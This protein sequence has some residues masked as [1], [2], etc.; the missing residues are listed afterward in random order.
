MSIEFPNGSVILFF[1]LD[2]KNRMDRIL[3]QEFLTIYCNEVSEISDFNAVTQLMTRLSQTCTSTS[4]KRARPKMLFDCNPPSKK[5]WTYQVF[6]EGIQPISKQP[7][8]N[9]TEWAW[10]RMNPV[11]NSENL[12]E[13]YFDTLENLSARQQKRFLQG[14][15]Q[16]EVDGALFKSDWFKRAN[17]DRFDYSNLV[18][19]VVAVDPPGSST[20]GSDEAGIVVVGI[21]ADDE[22]FVLEDASLR[23]TPDRWGQRSAD[24]Y[25]K[26]EADLI[27]AEKNQG[28]EM[29]E[30]TL[31]SAGKNLPIK[32]V[33]AS[34]GKVIRAEPISTLYEKGRVTHVGEFEE[35]EDQMENFTIDFSRTKNGSPDR[36][37]ALVWGIWEL[38][39]VKQHAPSV[40]IVG[41]AGGFFG[42]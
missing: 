20:P 34:R 31:T 16:S 11:D 1:G 15:W 41:R 4:G 40:A 6:V 8:K 35:L 27:V 21:D 22:V 3:G 18:R 37:D 17:P 12:N 10:I 33:H 7:L 38:T 19:I 26:W 42:S 30:K 28:G 39:Q 2:D 13:S 5:H 32:L 29:V 36:L 14:D 25:E 24:M 9:K 23:A